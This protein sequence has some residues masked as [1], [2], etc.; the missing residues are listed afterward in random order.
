[1]NAVPFGEDV[2]LHTGIPL[3]GAVPEVNAALKQGFHG[4]N[5]HVSPNFSTFQR[6]NRLA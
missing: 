4:N 2:R 6:A 1:M 3:V 5:S